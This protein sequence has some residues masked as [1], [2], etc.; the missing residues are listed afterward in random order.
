MKKQG[1]ASKTKRQGS[2]VLGALN[3]SIKAAEWLN[4]SDSAAVALAR[5]QAREIDRGNIAPQTVARYLDTL[6]S[7]GLTALSRKELGI[8]RRSKEVNPLDKIRAIEPVAPLRLITSPNLHATEKRS[9][10]GA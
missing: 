4:K 6:K 3:R 8:D 5:S 2:A 9:E 1:G 7:L 10:P